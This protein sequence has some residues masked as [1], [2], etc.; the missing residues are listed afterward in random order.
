MKITITGLAGV[1]TSTTG[2]LL[3]QKLGCEFMS[4][5]N[6]FRSYAD[7]LDI[8]LNELETKA[9]TDHSFD[10]EL[11]ARQKKYG[12]ENDTFV[13]ESRLGYYFIPDSVKVK[14]VCDFDERIRRISQREDRS[15]EEVK[16]LTLER[17]EAIRIRYKDLYDI[18]NF[19]DDK[20]FDLVIDTTTTP[21][22]K[23]V[24]ALIYYIDKQRVSK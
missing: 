11:D 4:G 13:F 3:A 16:K 23:L 8:S 15:I 2:K 1:G 24:Q 9:L 17:E 21:P 19:T 12:E 7:E 10:K 14:F 18:D 22:E 20:H 6:I 5:G